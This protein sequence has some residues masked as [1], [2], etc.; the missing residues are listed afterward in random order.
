MA[1]YILSPCAGNLTW[2]LDQNSVVNISGKISNP[3]WKDLLIAWSKIA[4]EPKVFEDFLNQP[5]WNNLHI[6]RNGKVIFWKN[7]FLAGIQTVRDLIDQNTGKPYEREVFNRIFG[8]NADFLRYNGIILSIP[9]EW[10]E[11]ILRNKDKIRN[12]IE[13]RL[14]KLLNTKEVSKSYYI[15][16]LEKVTKKEKKS[17]TTW[18]SDNRVINP[19]WSDIYKLPFE[20][21]KETKIQEF[22]Y[23]I[24]RRLLWTNFSLQK[25]N[26]IQNSR[27]SFCFF[28]TE[29][30]EHLL[31]ECRISHNL[32]LS[33]I[34]NLNL[35]N[36]YPEFEY[37]FSNIIFGVLPAS[38]ENQAL[39]TIILL[40]KKYIYNSRCKDII[41]NLQGL[42]SFLKFKINIEKNANVELE[43]ID[44][45]NNKWQNFRILFD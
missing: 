22:Q 23:L 21:T 30:T 2:L 44:K 7:W 17:E 34:D 13:T 15:K 42:I 41:P 25:A 28:C 45:F 36:I 14:S 10:R 31:F 19:N 4:E 18:S 27:C 33:V 16:F 5:V 35:M 32:W 26:V 12:V 6:L 39:N 9:K 40:T 20:C 29:T 24:N 8:L 43:A 37:T 3:F 11:S 1:Q 38:R